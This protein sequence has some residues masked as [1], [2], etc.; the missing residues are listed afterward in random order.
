MNTPPGKTA[1][2]LCQE[3]GG[4]E[5]SGGRGGGHSAP[6]GRGKKEKKLGCRKCG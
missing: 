1:W 2:M 6:T 3:F 4:A 5:E